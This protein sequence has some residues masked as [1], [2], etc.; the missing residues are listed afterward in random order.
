MATNGNSA[1]NRYAAR[2]DAVLRDAPGCAVRSRREISALL[3]PP[4]ILL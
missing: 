1:A 3:A 4:A 2:V